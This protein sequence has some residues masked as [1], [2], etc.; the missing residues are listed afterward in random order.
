VPDGVS[1]A[2]YLRRETYTVRTVASQKGY[3]IRCRRRSSTNSPSCERCSTSAT[4]SPSMTRS[5]DLHGNRTQWGC[6][7]NLGLFYAAIPRLSRYSIGLRE[8]RESLIRF[9]LYQRM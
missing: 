5:V 6:G 7:K 9:A 2:D 1:P 4:F 3:L 8:P